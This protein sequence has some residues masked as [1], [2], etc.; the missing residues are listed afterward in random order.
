MKKTGTLLLAALAACILLSGCAAGPPRAESAATAPAA[1]SAPP[2]SEAPSESAPGA[3]GEEPPE[4]VYG[5]QIQ[6]GTY[7]IEVSSSSSMFR[8][9]D[10][11]LTVENGEMS[12]VLTLGGKG[13]EKL[14]MGTGEQALAD[15]DDNCVYFSE[16]AQGRY[17]YRVPVAALDRETDCAAWSIRKGKWYDRVL[18]F[19]S[20]QLPD[21]AVSAASPGELPADGQYLV[22][23]SLSGGSGRASVESPAKVT[24]ADGRATAV[25]VWSS[26]YYESM[27]VDGAVYAPI[28][29]GGNSA[30]EIPVTLDADMAVSAR[31]I[32]MSEPHDVDYILRFDS[33]TAAPSE[34]Q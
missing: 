5:N 26:P 9:V 2:A 10:A 15:T 3:P 8:I 20:E 27:R 25:V 33:A 19:H 31:T 4:P 18:V 24:V 23:V 12:A 28:P 32:A 34:P 16:D 29:A 6:D 11:Q 7:P 1:E 30:F 22:D 17:T 21:G 13:Y 14:Y